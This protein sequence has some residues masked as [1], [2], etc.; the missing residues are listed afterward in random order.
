M[1]VIAIRNCFF[2]NHQTKE[3]SNEI[4]IHKG[5]IYHV[6]DKIHYPD[7]TTFLD[8][9]GYYNPN[10]TWFYSL[11]EVRGHHAEFLFLEIPEDVEEDFEIENTQQLK[12]HFQIKAK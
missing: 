1:R 11:L 7:L 12:P 3:I 5:S 10:G 8:E 9:P 6:L 2:S 4:A